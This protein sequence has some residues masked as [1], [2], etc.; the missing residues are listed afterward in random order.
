MILGMGILQ[1]LDFIPPDEAM[2]IQLLI[3]VG[4]VICNFC[5]SSVAKEMCHASMSLSALTSQCYI[6]S[7]NTKVVRSLKMFS[8]ETQ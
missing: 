5:A 1:P 3:I 4:T 2:E 8:L 6:T 7:Q